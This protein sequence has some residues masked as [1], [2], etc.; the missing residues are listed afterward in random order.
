MVLEQNGASYTITGLA[1]VDETNLPGFW[2]LN[3]EN[4][5]FPD[6]ANPDYYINPR[7]ICL[8]HPLNSAAYTPPAP[9]RSDV[10]GVVYIDGVG[11][12]LAFS[13]DIDSPTAPQEARL[14]PLHLVPVSGG[15][16]YSLPTCPP[17]PLHPP[18]P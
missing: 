2:I 4:P 9:W 18:F 13:S 7:C 10:L 17:P 8:N 11:F 5:A 6:L 12:R 15:S 14:F 16:S 3:P 1:E